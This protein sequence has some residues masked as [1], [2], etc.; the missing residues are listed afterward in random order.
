MQGIVLV[1]FIYFLTPDLT[2]VFRHH[3]SNWPNA[4]TSLTTLWPNSGHACM[5]GGVS[6][7]LHVPPNYLLG[8]DDRPQ[9]CAV[10]LGVA[11][12]CPH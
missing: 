4:V 10:P 2:A 9:G 8:G 5:Q 6:T 11:C 12:P 1:I 3:I 7:L